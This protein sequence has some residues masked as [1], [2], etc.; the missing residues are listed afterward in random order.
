MTSEEKT[1][2]RLKDAERK[3]H[4]ISWR[5]HSPDREIFIRINDYTGEVD[6]CD[7]GRCWFSVSKRSTFNVCWEEEECDSDESRSSASDEGSA[8]SR[9]CVISRIPTSTKMKVVFEVFANAKGISQKGLCFMLNGEAIDPDVTCKNWDEGNDEIDCFLATRSEHNKHTHPDYPYVVNDEWGQEESVLRP[10]DLQKKEIILRYTVGGGEERA[11]DGLGYT[12]DGAYRL[13]LEDP[14]SADLH[15]LGRLSADGEFVYDKGGF[16]GKFDYRERSLFSNQHWFRGKLRQDPYNHAIA[17]PRAR[18]YYNEGEMRDILS[19]LTMN[20]FIRFRNGQL[21]GAFLDCF[22]RFVVQIEE[23]RRTNEQV[24]SECKL[25]TQHATL[26]IGK[27]EDKKFLSVIHHMSHE[28]DYPLLLPTR[29]RPRWQFNLWPW[30]EKCR[31]CLQYS[32]LPASVANYIKEHHGNGKVEVNRKDVVVI[33][34]K[35]ARCK[36]CVG[37]RF[38]YIDFL[39]CSMEWGD[40]LHFCAWKRICEVAEGRSMAKEEIMNTPQAIDWGHRPYLDSDSK[41]VLRPRHLQKEELR[42]TGPDGFVYAFVNL[43]D[44]KDSGLQ[45]LGR[46]ESITHISECKYDENFKGEYDY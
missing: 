2:Y 13:N 26:F 29:T 9:C 21:Y 40:P 35:L 7:K 39:Q 42:I 6:R 34:E 24:F 5:P 19:T 1:A 12:Y 11:Y 10:H 14:E 31:I 44:Q 15:Y 38:E 37:V 8:S 22:G 16:R 32:P 28:H 46:D 30:E 33:Y 45:Y 3:K 27:R 23:G 36:S 25:S 18:F 20:Q 4:P 43:A 41:R 17:T